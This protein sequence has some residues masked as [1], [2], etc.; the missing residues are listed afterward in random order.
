ML[1]MLLNSFVIFKNFLSQSFHVKGLRFLIYTIQIKTEV[2]IY[3]CY[4][5]FVVLLE[6][7]ENCSSNIISSK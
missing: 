5:T 4:L 6:V 2:F 1:I 3:V 7:F